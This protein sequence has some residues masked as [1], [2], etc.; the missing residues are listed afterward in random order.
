MVDLKD[1]AQLPGSRHMVL[2]S[3]AGTE[4]LQ[5]SHLSIVEQPSHE[6]RLRTPVISHAVLAETAKVVRVDVARVQ[7]KSAI[8]GCTSFFAF[9]PVAKQR[10]Q[11]RPSFLP[12][13]QSHET[14]GE[15]NSSADGNHSRA[16]VQTFLA[17]WMLA[18]HTAK[19]S[20]AR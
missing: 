6:V 8:E 14:R 17:R 15:V 4:R 19:E 10:A 13:R 7:R 16:H 9:S 11:V 2:V 12:R 1:K 18:E 20:M 5:N 3:A